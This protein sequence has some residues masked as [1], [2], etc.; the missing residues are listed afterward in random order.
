[1]CEVFSIAALSLARSFEHLEAFAE[2]NHRA[3]E[4]ASLMEV[5]Q[6]INS[7]L[8]LGEVLRQVM[9]Q[10]TRLLGA[11]SSALMLL[12]ESTQELVFE[13]ATG[14]KGAAV[15]Q[16]RLKLGEGVAGW[17]AREGQPL[18]VNDPAG[19]RALLQAGGRDDRVH[20]AQHHRR[21]AHG[22]RAGDRRARGAQLAA[23]GAGV[24]RRA[25]CG[26][27]RR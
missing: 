9:A 4:I 26:C 23:A 11:E 1:M 12:E 10:S 13:V 14:D 5:N 16:I 24:R 15:K 7:T 19:G 20:D 18:I 17:V 8:D 6:V 22:P 27:S 3:T 2:I 21:P 25:T